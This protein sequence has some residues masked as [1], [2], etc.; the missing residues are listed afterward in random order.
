LHEQCSAPCMGLSHDELWSQQVHIFYPA[1]NE[2]EKL[3][4]V[5][6]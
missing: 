4:Q 1:Y 5:I 3:D 2:D 6:Q